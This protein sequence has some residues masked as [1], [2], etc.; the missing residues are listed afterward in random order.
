MS[1]TASNLANSQSPFTPPTSPVSDASMRSLLIQNLD[2]RAIDDLLGVFAEHGH[3]YTPLECSH[4]S[5]CEVVGEAA[6]GKGPRHSGSSTQCI[7][8]KGRSCA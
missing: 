1:Q 6:N 3:G 5:S 2:L 7:E 8:D 4:M